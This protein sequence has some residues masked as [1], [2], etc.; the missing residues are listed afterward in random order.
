[1]SEV[2]ILQNINTAITLDKPEYSVMLNNIGANLS[3]IDKTSE[4]FHKSHSQFMNVTLDV[5]TLTPMRSLMHV[6]AEIDKTKKALQENYFRLSKFKVEL[7][8]KKKQLETCVDDFDR[9]ILA[10]EIAEHECNIESAKAPMQ[11]AIRIMNF[12][13]NQY[14]SLLAL[15][16]KDSFTEEDF[17]KEEVKHH[18]ITAFKQALTAAR[19]RGGVVDEGNMIYFFDLGIN[20][21]HAQSEILG[22]LK[23]EEEMMK[24]GKIPAHEM[25]LKWLNN[26][27]EIF[28]DCPINSVKNKGFTL[29]DHTSLHQLNYEAV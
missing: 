13:I 14:N 12:F 25:T 29:L 3:K 17:E 24:D 20:Q 7:E 9:Q 21:A 16:G 22:Y 19:S 26:C 27:A 11:S 1:M 15:T 2:T 28:K 10:I 5:T 4:N 23:L 18:I 8:R 6:S